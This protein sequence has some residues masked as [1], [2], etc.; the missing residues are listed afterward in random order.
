MN[1]GF[2]SPRG[3][4]IERTRDA[5]SRVHFYSPGGPPDRQNGRQPPPLDGVQVPVPVE[6]EEKSFSTFSDLQTGQITF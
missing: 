2:D 4:Q 5:R 6:K 1:Q 3:Y